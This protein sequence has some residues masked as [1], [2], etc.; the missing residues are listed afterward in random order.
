MKN[1]RDMTFLEDA[2]LDK[3]V[4]LVFELAA[5]L[6][7]ERQRRLALE[8]LMSDKGLITAAEMENLADD[9]KFLETARENLDRSLRKLMR[10]LSEQ[11]DKK[12]PLRAEALDSE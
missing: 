4:G 1:A 7:V 8:K 6:H 11:G 5:Q 3:T 9:D 12:G 2:D 10:V